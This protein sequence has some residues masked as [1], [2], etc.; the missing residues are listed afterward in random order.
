MV[1]KDETQTIIRLPQSLLD[2]MKHL[3]GVNERSVNGELIWALRRYAE[4]HKEKQ[5]APYAIIGANNDQNLRFYERYDEHFL[6]NKVASFLYIL[7]Q[8]EPVVKQIEEGLIAS[9]GANLPKRY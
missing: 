4:M 7:D 9:G 1:K 8:G 3:A 2:N 5:P 6:F